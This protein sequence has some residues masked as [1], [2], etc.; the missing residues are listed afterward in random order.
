[1]LEIN[2]THFG[3][4]LDLMSKIDDKSIDM[5]LWDNQL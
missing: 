3:D 1:M 5:I 2:K 4:C